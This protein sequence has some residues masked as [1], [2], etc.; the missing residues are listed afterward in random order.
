MHTFYINT[1]INTGII[2]YSD[3]Y[4]LSIVIARL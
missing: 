2:Y 4:H 3:K 1:C